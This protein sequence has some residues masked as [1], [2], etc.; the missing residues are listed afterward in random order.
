MLNNQTWQLSHLEKIKNLAGTRYTP[1]LNVELPISEIF[2]GISRT[3]NFYHSIR[4][5]FGKF[6]REFKRV[7]SEYDKKRTQK[8]YDKLEDEVKCLLNLLNNIKDFNTSHIPWKNIKTH[9][10]RANT[11]SFDL[12][13]KL[14]DEKHKRKNVVTKKTENTLYTPVSHKLESNLHHLYKTQNELEYFEEQAESTKAKLSNNPFLMLTGLAGTGKTHLLCDL[15]EGRF[16]NKNPLPAVLTFGEF[17]IPGID[18]AEQIIKQIGLKNKINK[19]RIFKSLNT[20]GEKAGTRAILIIDALNETT[21]LKF[22]KRNLNPIINEVKKYPHIALIISIRSGFEEEVLTKKNRKLFIYEEHK[23]FQFRE[24]EAVTKFFNEFSLPLPEIPL[25]MPEFQNPL[26]LL[27]FCKAFEKRAKKSLKKRG[28]KQKQIFRGHEGATYIFENFVKSRAD[29]IAGKFG[30]P[31]GRD[32]KGDYVIWDTVIEK[33]AA[34]M[35]QQYSDR[36]SEKKLYEIIQRNYLSVDS[37]SFVTELEKNLLLIK[38]PKYSNEKDANEKFEYRFPFQKFSDHLIG[39]YIFREYTKEFGAQGKNL[40]TAKRF[41]SRRRKLGKFLSSPW[42]MGIVEALSVQCPEQLKGL[43]FVEV[44]P[45]L[46]N[47]YCAYCVQDAFIESLIWRRP[48]AFTKDL[49]NTL[50]YINTYIARTEHKNNLLLNAFLSV[51]YIPEHPL[52][53]Y[54]LHQHLSKF[55]LAIRDSWWSTFL[56]NQYK[57]KGAVDRLV[58]WGW[59]EH[60]KNHIKDE[61]IKLCAITLAWFLTTSN[62]FLRDKAT[63]ALVALLTNRINIITELLDQFKK[64]NDPYVAER[65][66]AVA[67]GC[68]LRNADDKTNL[69]KLSLW[70]CKNVFKNGKPYP[71]ILLRDYARGIIEV[72]LRE[73]IKMHI[74]V[75]HIRPPYKSTWP[76]RVP[77]EKVLRKKYYPKEISKDRKYVSIW[78]SVMYSYGSL[79]DFGNYV[80]NSA[81]GHWSARKLYNKT[82]VNSKS[83]RVPKLRWK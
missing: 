38:I 74:N 13:A 31:K 26:F 67:Y 56:H 24:W 41:F 28:R 52:N 29:Q 40:T 1:K 61:S 36:I 8:L 35:V 18:P 79:A 51:A 25:L 6:S 53:A 10:Q 58:E 43:E 14:R 12:I 17:F 57:E 66:Y 62:R 21:P 81:V 80:L 59:S 15:V 39:R 70:V 68:V 71:H 30:L 69:K 3:E 49:K 77:S 37:D 27:L 50:K 78:S 4:Q 55:S 45:Y 34:E 65:L 5:H 32:Q 54:Y 60:D 2:D 22:W 16:Q 46:Q 19:T 72:A 48:D 75:S 7:S 42:S 64:V 73:N 33:V 44:A 11:H 47:S 23:G 9:A 83:F 82:Q 20:A 76:K 63:K